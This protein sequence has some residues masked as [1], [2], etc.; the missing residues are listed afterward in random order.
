MTTLKTYGIGIIGLGIMGQRM[1][2]AL[3][4]HPR[5]RVVGAYDPASPAG[6]DLGRV[7]APAELA[8]HPAVDCLYV[9]SPP[10]H[11]AAG[12]DLA[13]QFRKPIV[14]EKPLSSTVDEAE[15]M[16]DRIAAAK[17]P[18]AVNFYLAAAESATRMRQL[19]ASGALGEIREA[20]LTLRFK[21]WPRPWQSRAG[22]WLSSS[23]EGG[24]TREV[25]SHFLFQAGRIFGPGRCAE[26]SVQRGSDGT[27]TV[28]RARIDYHGVSLE[29]D[30]A[31]ADG[32]DEYNR[33]AI[34]GTK[35]K[36]AL[37][38]WD[39]LDYAGAI[40]GLPAVPDA[41]DQLAAMLDGKPHQL[42][43]FDE[44]AAVARLTEALLA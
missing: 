13:I 9:A 23:R 24:Y 19:A 15:S 22:A 1:A 8:E 31:I 12:V 30:G 20:R 41:L 27:E 3:K 32:P 35:G 11:H 26:T 10:A 7:T 17:L 40:D 29:I 43:T 5:F 4:Q 16:R 37:V 38:D 42:A 28:L 44:G 25:G 6:S 39:E 34:T 21:A 33:F 14:C 18:A 2:E 36:A